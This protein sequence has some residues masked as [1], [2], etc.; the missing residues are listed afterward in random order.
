MS[1]ALLSIVVL[2]ARRGS[3]AQDDAPRADHEAG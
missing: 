3:L 1:F 2:V